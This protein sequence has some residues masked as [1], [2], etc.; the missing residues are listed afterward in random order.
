VH[1]YIYI[2]CEYYPLKLKKSKNKN[3]FSGDRKRSDVAGG[4]GGEA[5]AGFQLNVSEFVLELLNQFCS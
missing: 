3:F 2:K 5:Q 1:D 4:R